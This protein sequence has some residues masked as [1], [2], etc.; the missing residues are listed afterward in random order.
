VVGVPTN[1]EFGVAVN[2]FFGYPETFGNL[3][4]QALSGGED[5]NGDNIQF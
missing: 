1:A 5:T 2:H 3:W 4:F